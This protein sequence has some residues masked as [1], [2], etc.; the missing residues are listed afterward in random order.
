MV[1]LNDLMAHTGAV[2]HT[3]DVTLRHYLHKVE[4]T[5]VVLGQEDEVIIALF[6]EPVV[7]FGNID[8]TADDG[9]HIGVLLCKFEELL[10][11]VHVAM[12]R[13]GKGRHTQFIGPVEE[14]FYGRLSVQD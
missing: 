4:V 2:V 13:Y 12:V 7:T 10:D 1:L 14:V 8:L 9:L 6:L 11:A 5:G 3:V